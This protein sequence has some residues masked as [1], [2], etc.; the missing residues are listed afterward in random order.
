MKTVV[1]TMP[2]PNAPANTTAG[3]PDAWNEFVTHVAGIKESLATALQDCVADAANGRL[4]LRFT[5]SFHLD[6]VNRSTA[7]LRE[8]LQKFFAGLMLETRLEKT[9][10]PANTTA[11]KPAAAPKPAAA[12]RAPI[13]ANDHLEEISAADAGAHVQEALK[14]FQGTVKREKKSS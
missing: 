2:A 11:G 9:G 14:H 13:S 10:Q 5:K 3:Q 8:P 6:M 7:L 12:E 1:A 4:L